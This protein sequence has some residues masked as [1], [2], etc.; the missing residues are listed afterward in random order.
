MDDLKCIGLFLIPAWRG[1]N[2]SGIAGARKPVL[3]EP[4]GGSRKML[5]GLDSLRSE[6]R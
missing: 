1:K 4:A 3:E 6:Q 5:C 2:N